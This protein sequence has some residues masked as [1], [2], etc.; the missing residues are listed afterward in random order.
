MSDRSQA[1]GLRVRSLADVHLADRLTGPGCPVCGARARAVARYLDGWLGES[2]NDV[3]L[4]AELDRARGLCGDHTGALLAA[5]RRGAG[6]RLASAILLDA[7][8]RVRAAELATARTA[9]GRGRGR[10]YAAAA[11]PPACLVCAT[12]AAAEASAVTGIAGYLDDADWVR[13]AGAAAFCLAH[14]VALLG[15]ADGPGAAAVAAEQAA[16]VDAVRALL[17]AYGMNAAFDRRHLQRPEEAAAVDAAAQLLGA[18]GAE[19]PSR[20]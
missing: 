14:L 11:R 7:I 9:R 15:V 17:T 19:T 6:G 12:E 20:G 5:E 3:T 1:G 2:V 8:L 18:P 16:R 13:A 10:A 4:R